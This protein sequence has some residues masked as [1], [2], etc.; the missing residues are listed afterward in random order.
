MT[1][2]QPL[3][4]NHPIFNEPSTHPTT[5]APAELPHRVQPRTHRMT[6]CFGC[7]QPR[8]TCRCAPIRS[9]PCVADPAVA[10]G[11]GASG[12]RK[13]KM[14]RLRSGFA[15]PSPTSQQRNTQTL[16]TPL[17]RLHTYFLS[18]PSAGTH[19]SNLEHRAPAIDP[20]SSRTLVPNSIASHHRVL[21]SLSLTPHHH[22]PRSRGTSYHHRTRIG[23]ILW[24][25]WRWLVRTERDHLAKASPTPGLSR[26]GLQ[27]VRGWH[28][29]SGRHWD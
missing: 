14:Q 9:P 21:P 12:R 17:P 2:L 7:R 27:P 26:V 3:Q 5:H 1:P 6:S 4:P 19:I 22:P 8:P 23:L 11:N 25:H 15:G 13:T 18:Q 16:C 10:P 29:R 24:A 28:G 20:T